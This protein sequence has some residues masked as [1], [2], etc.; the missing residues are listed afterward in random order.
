MNGSIKFSVVTKT[1]I[2]KKISS[3][4]LDHRKYIYMTVLIS[5]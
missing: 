4:T 2:R 1:V 5:V 3:I